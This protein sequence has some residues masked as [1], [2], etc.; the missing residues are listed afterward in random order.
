MEYDHWTVQEDIYNWTTLAKATFVKEHLP[1]IRTQV[2]TDR[3]IEP[4]RLRAQYRHWASKPT[5]E[6]AHTTGDTH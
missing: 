5:P 4:Q 3:T 6:P 1:P 2:S